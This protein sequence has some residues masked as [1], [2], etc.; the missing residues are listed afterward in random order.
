MSDDKLTPRYPIYIP[1]R[2]RYDY[3]L[4]ARFLEKDGVPFRFVVEPVEYEEYASRFGEDRVLKLPFDNVGVEQLVTVRNWIWDHSREAGDVRHWQLDD[5]MRYIVRY[6]HGSRFRT[7]AGAAIR[8]TEDFIDRYANVGMGGINYEM[9][10]ITTEKLPP[11]R[12]NCHIYSTMLMLNSLPLRWRGPRNEDIDMCLQVLASGWCTIQMNIFGVKKLR[13]MTI[14]G[15]NTDIYED[16][17]R[18]KMTR[19]LTQRWPGVVKLTRRF[20]RP[21]HW[22]NWRKFDTPLQFRDDFD[23]ADLPKVDEHG[24]TL[25]KVQPPKS[26]RVNELH[27][28][29]HDTHK[30]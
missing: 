25:V 20:G 15:G 19:V 28:Q 29:Y 5:N 11:F 24:L 27:A 4:T 17:G 2:G 30:K 13:T 8:M 3:P 10:Q 22:I 12:L 14:K 6:Y 18:L 9:F 23:P 21:H 26:D 16:D 1:S 7:H